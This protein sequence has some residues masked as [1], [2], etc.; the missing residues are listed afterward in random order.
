VKKRRAIESAPPQPEEDNSAV[1]LAAFEDFESSV[2]PA[3]ESIRADDELYRRDALLDLELSLVKGVVKET[4]GGVYFAWS[5][6]LR[7]M[8]IGATRREDPNIRLKELSRYVTEP[9]TLAAFI[10]STMP[11]RTEV[12]V[13][14]YFSSSRLRH[15]GAG[16]EFFDIGE[17]EAIDFVKDWKSD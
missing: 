8:K 2:L 3:L 15:T 16:T 17:L 1:A 6:C 14:V 4:T 5:S 9:F 12:L 7:C 13:H 10:P 11:F